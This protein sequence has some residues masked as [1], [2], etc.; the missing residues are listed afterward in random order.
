MS[1]HHKEE[2]EKIR[3]ESHAFRQ[4]FREW[5]KS[6]EKKL[7]CDLK[8]K[9]TGNRSDER[10]EPDN[11]DLILFDVT[12]WLFSCNPLDGPIPFIPSLPEP[13]QPQK[14]NEHYLMDMQLPD[15]PTLQEPLEPVKIKGLSLHFGVL[16]M[17]T[18][19]PRPDIPFMRKIIKHQRTYYK[20]PT[21][22]DVRGKRKRP[23]TGKRC[24]G[25]S[26]ERKRQKKWH[27]MKEPFD[28][29]PRKLTDFDT[30][31]KAC[32][33]DNRQMTAARRVMQRKQLEKGAR[34]A[35]IT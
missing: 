4:E 5:F 27:G 7:L 17:N 22:K 28:F 13:L 25:K 19:L 6:F 20:Q 1:N 21:A 8:Q 9:S 31:R 33:Q 12:P 3:A 23:V 24:E 34:C 32:D 30:T 10:P 15:I 26:S 14:V 18:L 11:E 29:G 2:L 16:R 35:N